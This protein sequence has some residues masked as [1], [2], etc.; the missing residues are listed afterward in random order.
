M[1]DV[2]EISCSSD[3]IAAKRERMQCKL[4]KAVE[5]KKKKI[6]NMLGSNIEEFPPEEEFIHGIAYLKGHFFIF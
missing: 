5:N 3:N 6:D 4:D 1:I 2:L